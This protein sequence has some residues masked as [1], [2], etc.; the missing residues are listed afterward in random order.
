MF[1]AAVINLE[2]G[3]QEAGD[4]VNY[5]NLSDGMDAMEELA[6]KLIDPKKAAELVAAK[7]RAEQEAAAKARAEREVTERVWIASDAA[8]FTRAIAAINSDTRDGE[9]TITLTNSFTS[10]P[11]T[12][13][14]NTSKTI[15]LKGDA[16]VRTILNKGGGNLF[17]VPPGITL[18]LENNLTLNGN[19]QKNSVV[20]VN[21]GTLSMKAG[22]TVHGAQASGVSVAGG[23]FTMSNGTISG[24]TASSYGGGVSVAGGAFTMSGGTISG[25]TV[26]SGSGGGVS[27]A[28]GTFMMTGGTISGNSASSYHGGGVIV[29]GG[30]FTMSGGT[31][32][33]NSASYG[34][35]V[36]VYG[37]AFTK[38]GGGTIDNTNWAETGRVAYVLDGSKKRD[39]AAGPGVNLNSRVSGSAGGWE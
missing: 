14:N 25:N 2:T 23:A 22:S 27:V 33:G 30:T 16:A 39:S 5:Q 10:G 24:N 15:T 17:T 4:T 8:S 36:S 35:G 13:T 18:A 9:Y 7:A 34:G 21:G 28:I 31:I 1:N 32:S 12:F 11:V 26:S 38:S 29:Q 3:V 6:L 19:N 37:G 20:Y